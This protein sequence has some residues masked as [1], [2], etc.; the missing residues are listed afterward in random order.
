MKEQSKGYEEFLNCKD[1]IIE[2][3][4]KGHTIISVFRILTK[5]G[6]ITMKNKNFYRILKNE[7]IGKRVLSPIFY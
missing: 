5:N 2:L 1:E 4:H 7:G 6:K 3:L